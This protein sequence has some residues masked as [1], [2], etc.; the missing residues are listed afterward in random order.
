NG[1]SGYNYAKWNLESRHNAAQHV[2]ADTR[3]QPK[4]EEE[5]TLTPD[6]RLVCDVA[7]AYMFSAAQMHS[8]VPNT[9]R[10]T[11]YSVDFRTV[12]LDDVE[13]GTGAPNIDSACTG[14]S[15]GDFLRASDFA[16]CPEE[17]VARLEAVPA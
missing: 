11:R 5:M 1:S 8:T 10:V 3:V 16:R 7:G 14:S 15:I 9:S 17:I 13:S 2:K 12:N 4:P 6:V